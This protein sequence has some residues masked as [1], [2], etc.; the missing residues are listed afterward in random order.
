MVWCD[1]MS[2]W[3]P[4]NQITEVKPFLA[5]VPPP[6]RRNPAPASPPLVLPPVPSVAPKPLYMGPALPS[7]GPT[8]TPHL[9][10]YLIGGVVLLVLFLMALSGTFGSLFRNASPETTETEVTANSNAV[11]GGGGFDTLSVVSA[12]SQAAAAAEKERQQKRAWNREHFMEYV[13]T[14]VNSGYSVG[15]LGG[16]SNGTLTIQNKSGYRL[17]NVVVLVTYYKPDGSSIDFRQVSLST[18]AAHDEQQLGFP[19]SNRGVR[20]ECEFVSLSAPGL[21][22]TFGS[23]NEAAE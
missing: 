10:Y 19:D 5:P 9:N 1:G 22:Y 13:T 23:Q 21:D 7:T 3:L 2:E 15:M 11:M 8:T 16:I 4:A 20:A 6:I 14:Y 18:L 12:E 17:E